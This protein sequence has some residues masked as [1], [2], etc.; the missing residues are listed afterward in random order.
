MENKELDDII[1]QQT[2]RLRSF[3]RG[4]VSNREDAEDIVQDTLYQLVRSIRLLENPIG[5]VTS[6]L[7]TVAHNLIVNHDKKLREEPWPETSSTD[8]DNYLGDLSEIMITDDGDSPDIK[9]LREMV[10][11]ELDK[12]MDELP[13]EQR[14]AIILTEV[15]GLSVKEAAERMGVTVGTFLSRKHYGVMHIR[16]RLKVLY[17]ELSGE[18]SK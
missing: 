17:Q 16:K 15:D 3:V 7:Y 11:Q 10:W 8:D 5:Q 2:P 18:N 6:W 14:Q 13:T 12:A 4:R 1:K 9:L